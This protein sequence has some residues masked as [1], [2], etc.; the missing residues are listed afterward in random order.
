MSEIASPGDIG[1]SVRED[2]YFVYSRETDYG[3]VIVQ[4]HLY[5][6]VI[7]TY[8]DGRIVSKEPHGSITTYL[9]NGGVF[10]ESPD[11]RTISLPLD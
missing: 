1:L 6:K 3:R 2:G 7:E 5:G 10:I 4:E 11:G 8:E 9:P